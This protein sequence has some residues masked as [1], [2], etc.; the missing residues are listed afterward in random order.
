MTSNLKFD[1]RKN[2]AYFLTELLIFHFSHFVLLFHHL[3]LS[4]V[5][6]GDYKESESII[7]RACLLAFVLDL[8]LGVTCF[9]ASHYNTNT[10]CSR[11]IRTHF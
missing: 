8:F 3:R 4:M 2:S 5:S 10:E 1:C 11:K 9:N 7:I 6:A